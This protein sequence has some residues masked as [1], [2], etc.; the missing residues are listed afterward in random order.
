[1]LFSYLDNNGNKCIVEKNITIATANKPTCS[2]PGKAIPENLKIR[3]SPPRIHMTKSNISQISVAC[4]KFCLKDLKNH[5]VIY[6]SSFFAIFST[7]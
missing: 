6:P 4:L 1:M 5:F 3:K 2:H 7:T